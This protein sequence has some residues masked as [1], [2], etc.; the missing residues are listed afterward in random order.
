MMPSSTDPGVHVVTASGFGRLAARVATSRPWLVIIL[1]AVLSVAALGLSGWLQGRLTIGQSDYTDP[2]AESAQGRARI[3]DAT[4]I[5]AQEGLLILVRLDQT[6]AIDTPQPPRVD[7]VVQALRRQPDLVRVDTYATTHDPDMIATDGR[8]TYVVAQF[9]HINE[10]QVVRDL[11]QQLG[12]TPSLKGAVDIGGPTAIN[13]DVSEVSVKDLGFAESIALPILMVLLLIVFRGVVAALVPLLGGMLTILLAF[14]FLV[15]FAATLHISVFALNL[16]FGLGLGLSIDFSLLMVSRFREELAQDV[17][18]RAALLR[19]LD[20]AGRTIAFSC[21]TVSAALAAL[22]TFPQ[23]YL[24]SMSLAGILV[25]IAAGLTA[26]FGV[27]A[28][29]GLLGPRINALSLR[30]WRTRTGAEESGF[31]YRFPRVVM[32]HPGVLAIGVAALMIGLSLP[33]TGIRFTGVDAF[34][35]PQGVS[36]RTVIDRLR[37]DFPNSGYRI[38]PVT[39]VLA[40][41]PDRG[42]DVGDYAGR[43]GRTS[44]VDLVAPPQYAGHD[45]WVVTA[46][47]DQEPLSGTAQQ[48]VTDVRAIPAPF[49]RWVTGQTA[50]FIDLDRSLSSHLPLALLLVVLTTFV[51]LFLLTGSVI[52][53][54]KALV[55]TLLSLGAAFGVL[56]VVF[57]DGFLHSLLGFTPQPGLESSTPLLIFALV[58]GLSTDYEVFLLSRIKEGHDAGA[59]LRNA[60]ATGL[61]RT[62]RIVTAAAALFCVA[63]GALVLS[64]II[65]IKEL[66]LGTA[67]AVLIDATLVRAVLVPA[68]MVMLA[69]WNWWAPRPLRVLHDRLHLR[70][71]EAPAQPVGR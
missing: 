65:L 5:D 68:L 3:F 27:T 20:T 24:Y 1:F 70:W 7:Q 63:V 22:L 42:A 61:G 55:M 34:M 11:R 35:V 62:G 8:S 17:S 10:Q 59:D 46:F 38:S 56:V 26:L 19:T 54:V 23:P 66:G 43:I 18:T 16:V 15:P 71:G 52:L 67:F 30:R 47:I 14:L 40:A 60:V 58:L 2:R 44:G 32:R 6:V 51:V 41:P 37:S 28:A 69:D 12:D 48:A 9:R 57:K 49:P 29:L 39:V 25:T 21:L 36:S 53:P 45:T 33:I 13:I 4:G 64:R 31:W 50:T